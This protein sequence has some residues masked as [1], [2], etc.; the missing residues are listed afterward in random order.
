MENHNKSTVYL[1]HFERPYW[2]KCQHYLGYTT[3]PVIE[4]LK[5]HYSGNGS[6]LVAFAL[7]NGNSFKLSH[8]EEFDT[9]KEARAREIQLKIRGHYSEKCIICG[10]DKLLAST[11]LEHNES[12]NND[13]RYDVQLSASQLER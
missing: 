13:S 6:K 7:N 2:G 4:R 8:I 9:R 1:L 5:R 3:L 10:V 11:K 12:S